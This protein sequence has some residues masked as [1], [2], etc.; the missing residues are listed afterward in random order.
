MAVRGHSCVLQLLGG[1]PY[2]VTKMYAQ[3]GGGWTCNICGTRDLAPE[4]SHGAA[5]APKVSGVTNSNPYGGIPVT[6]LKRIP[7]IDE[8]E[9]EKEKSRERV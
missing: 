1:I 6:W 8:L 7:P 2:R 5:G 9:N 4:A 3:V